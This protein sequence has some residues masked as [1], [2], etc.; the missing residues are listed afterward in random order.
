[1]SGVT[2]VPSVATRMRIGSKLI[3]GEHCNLIYVE[4]LVKKTEAQ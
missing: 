2:L 3:S 4:E 1:M